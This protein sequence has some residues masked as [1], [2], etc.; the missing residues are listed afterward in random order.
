MFGDSL[1]LQTWSYV[2][3]IAADR[4]QPFDGGAYGGT[5]LCD[6]LPA[7]MS[8]L[9]DHK[10]AYLVLAF[11][12]NNLTRCSRGVRGR[13]LVGARLAALYLGDAQRAIAAARRVG[14]EVFLVGPPAMRDRAWDRDA[15][16]M[17][18]AMQGLAV[19][20]R[21]VA[22]LDASTVLSPHGYR[23]RQSCLSFETNAL[24][25]HNGSVV[26]RAPDGVHLSAPVDGESGYSSGAWRYATLLMRGIRNAR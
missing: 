13:R 4:D 10:P 7:I 11:A 6:W 23:F 16:D 19:R 1:V 21:G 8:S 17:R 14:T 3:R 24:G 5:A 22:Y 18:T 26:I 25:C 9:R 12:G 15:S 20:D 2:R